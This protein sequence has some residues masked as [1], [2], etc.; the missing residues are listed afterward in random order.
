M[1][2]SLVGKATVYGVP[3]NLLF[4]SFDG[5]TTVLA[6]ADNKMVGAA[7][8]D[9]TTKGLLKD[10]TGEVVGVC[11]NREAHQATFEIIPIDS[12]TPS[13]LATAKTKIELPAVG[14]KVTIAGF[15]DSTYDGDWHYAGG[16]SITPGASETDPIKVTLPCERYG[17]TPA[18]LT[19][20][21]T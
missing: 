15:G 8:T 9:V 14:A 16:G 3:G 13:S 18:F 17:T 11:Y 10:G 4:K 7:L 19:A 5:A 12:S 6:A 21:T 20:V 1:A 2:Q